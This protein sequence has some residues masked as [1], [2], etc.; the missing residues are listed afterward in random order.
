MSHIDFFIKQLEVK[1]R[2]RFIRNGK[3][4]DSRG[5]WIRPTAIFVVWEYNGFYNTDI[6]RMFGVNRKT[7]HNSINRGKNL[8]WAEDEAFE[9]Q[10]NK[11]LE[12][13]IQ[14]TR[15]YLKKNQ[16]YNLKQVA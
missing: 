2:V 14:T 8:R 13:Y 11:M 12:L 1:F 5:G 9:N 10:Y 15:V 3:R 16:I 7:V 6:G 4:G